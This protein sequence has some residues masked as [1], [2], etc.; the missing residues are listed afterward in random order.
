MEIQLNG[1]AYELP[2]GTTLATLIETLGI[3]GRLAVEVNEQIVPR[4]RFTEYEL[5]PRDRVEIVH[6]IGGG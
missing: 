4:G 1:E 3:E 2:A 5:Q 6:A